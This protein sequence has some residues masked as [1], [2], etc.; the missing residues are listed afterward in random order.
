MTA[1]AGVRVVPDSL[2]SV[3]ARYRELGDQDM[4]DVTG[5]T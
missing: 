2:E 3:W 4:D 1:I 5:T